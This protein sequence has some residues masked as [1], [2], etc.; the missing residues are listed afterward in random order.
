MSDNDKL[1]IEDDGYLHK[2]V[3]EA[4]LTFPAD[5]YHCH[6][7]YHCGNLIRYPI[8]ARRSDINDFSELMR[9][10]YRI[11]DKHGITANLLADIRADLIISI[12]KGRKE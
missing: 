11:M 8:I 2:F 3:A 4:L 1:L 7:C 10:A 12:A 9:S 6:P 5:N